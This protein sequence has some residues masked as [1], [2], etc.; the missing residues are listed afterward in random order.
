MPYNCTV[1]IEEIT[2]RTRRDKSAPATVYIKANIVTS[3]DRY[4]PML[5]GEG[6]RRIRSIGQAARKELEVAMNKKVFLELVV[7]VDERWMDRFE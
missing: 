2:D 4:R 5:L 1:E 6:G 3:A 7:R